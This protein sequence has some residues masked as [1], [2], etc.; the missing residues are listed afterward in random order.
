[1]K[2]NMDPSQKVDKSKDD[3]LSNRVMGPENAMAEHA[4]KLEEGKG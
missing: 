3:V 2:T 1:M 4:K